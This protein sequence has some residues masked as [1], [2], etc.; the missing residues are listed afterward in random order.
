MK[1]TTTK[2][3]YQVECF[4]KHHK[5]WISPPVWVRESLS[6]AE[7]LVVKLCEV[8]PVPKLQIVKVT[9]TEKREVLT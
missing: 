4:M 8:G 2:V 9:T 6:E 5:E 1:S 7:Y 3:V